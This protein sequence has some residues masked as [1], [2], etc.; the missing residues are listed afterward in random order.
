M[1]TTTPNIKYP[2]MHKVLVKIG[3]ESN[4]LIEMFTINGIRIASKAKN[5]WEL[6]SLN[7]KLY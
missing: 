1:M 6:I 4:L 2:E 7:Y 3:K 5:H